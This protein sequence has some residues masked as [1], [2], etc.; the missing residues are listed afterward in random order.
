ML[1]LTIILILFV[2]LYICLFGNY[3]QPIG[4]EGL[5]FSGFN[6]VTLGEVW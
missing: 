1:I 3:S 2:S 6:G 5:N 4:P